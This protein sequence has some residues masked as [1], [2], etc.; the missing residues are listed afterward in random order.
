MGRDRDKTLLKA[1][2]RHLQKARKRKGL[3][4]EAL[5]KASGLHR[6]YIIKLEMGEGNPTFLVLHDL[7][8]A[9]GL[10]PEDLTALK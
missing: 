6:R 9:M 7:A 4:Q 1:L 3:T 5:A 8:R 2:G 10:R